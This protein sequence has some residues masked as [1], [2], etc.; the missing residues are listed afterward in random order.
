ME[1][2]QILAFYQVARFKSFTKAASAVFR[3]QS[4]VSQ[5]IKALEDELEC[6]LFERIGRRRL[7]LTPAGERF[8]KFSTALLEQ[9]EQLLSELN[10]LK[11]LQIG[12]LKLG[13]IFTVFY[14]LLPK[15]IKKYKAELPLVD[16]NIIARPPL[17]IIDLVRSGDINFGIAMESVVPLDLRVLRWKVAD[18]ILLVP[19]G[20]P[21]ANEKLITPEQIGKYPL[22]LPSKDLKYTTRKRLEEKLTQLGIKFNIIMESPSVVLSLKYVEEGLGLSFVTFPLEDKRC[23]QKK[24]MKV[25]PLTHLFEPDHVVVI[26]RKNKPLA[27]YE[28]YF[29]D[30]LFGKKGY[31]ERG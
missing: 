1:W 16:L 20:H 6:R 26:L 27:Q 31:S 7:L 4:A 28:K 3:T 2:Q 8:L 12:H 30:L 13:S 29:I 11:G 5:Q 24:K 9:K 17:E 19:L 23:L 15:L 10:E 22:I 25:I 21:L 14:Y 18:T